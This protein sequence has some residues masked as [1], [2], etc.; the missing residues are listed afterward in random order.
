MVFSKSLFALLFIALITSPSF[1]KEFSILKYFNGINTNKLPCQM[2]LI[3]NWLSD[4]YMCTFKNSE[5]DIFEF[6]SDPISKEVFRFHRYILLNK[7]DVSMAIEQ[8]IKKYGEPRS[9]FLDKDFNPPLPTMVWGDSRLDIISAYDVFITNSKKGG[10]GLSSSFLK[11]EGSFGQ[12]NELFNV[13]G[14]PSTVVLSLM[15]YDVDRARYSNI[16][17]KTGKPPQP[18]KI[19]NTQDAA[20]LKY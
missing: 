11:C 6:Q 19:V 17:I 20:E 14:S 1:G 4:E 12:C 10:V 3:D 5:T 18:K 8:L 16:V 13:T 15:V 7:S 9:T 2:K